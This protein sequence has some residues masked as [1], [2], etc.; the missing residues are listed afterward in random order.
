MKKY[1][2]FKKI[3][4]KDTLD[5]APVQHKNI[6]QLT[7]EL[8]QEIKQLNQQFQKNNKNQSNFLRFLL[9]GMMQ[10]FGTIIGATI[11]VA[12]F[13]FL[14]RPFTNVNWIRPYVDQIIQII[15]THSKSG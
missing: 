3:K 10:G 6:E 2:K 14:L 5:H 9:I 13:L 11:L 7:I 8:L 12:L 15:Q 4:P 1:F